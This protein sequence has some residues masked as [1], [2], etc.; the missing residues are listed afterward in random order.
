MFFS[1]WEGKVAP[2][3]VSGQLWLALF[4]A[5]HSVV[6][7]HPLDMGLFQLSQAQSG[8]N[9]FEVTFDLN[10]KIGSA[11]SKKDLFSL[12][13]CSLKK[14]SVETTSPQLMRFS[15]LI[16]CE[17]VDKKLRLSFPFLS[18]SKIVSTFQVLVKSN[19]GGTEHLYSIDKTRPFIDLD[20]VSAGSLFSFVKMGME[21]I[22]ASLQEWGFL[23]R[24]PHFPDG[25]DHIL[26]LIALC[27]AG[28]SFLNLVKTAT[29]FTLGH[30]LTLALATLDLIHFPSKWVESAIA[31]SIAYVAAEDLFVKKSGQRFWIAVVFGLVHGFGFANALNELH[32]KGKELVYAL[33]GFN[34]G[35]EFGQVFFLTLFVLLGMALSRAQTFAALARTG[36]AFVV[37]VTGFVWFV[38]RAFHS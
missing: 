10:P 12:G 28:G 37:M 26:F 17:G 3:F 27:L 32:L 30:S 36:C 23:D 38:Q 25:I 13:T 14:E 8:V 31:L 20:T 16:F 22:G 6:N 9:Q 1:L 11:I 7:A 4:F 29:G 18:N 15:A 34:F 24:A 35:V 21:H 5:L 2:L 33:L 19:L